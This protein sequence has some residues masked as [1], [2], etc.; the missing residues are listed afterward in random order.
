M[1]EHTYHVRF[2][3]K[4]ESNFDMS[5]DVDLPWVSSTYPGSPR[6][7]TARTDMTHC[8]SVEADHDARVDQVYRSPVRGLPLV[9]K[10]RRRMVSSRRRSTIR[11]VHE[12]NSLT[13]PP[14]VVSALACREQPVASSTGFLPAPNSG[15]SG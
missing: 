9:Q 14:R 1:E 5:H 8:C 7:S 2:V 6:R 15:R 4:A 12:S 10:V 3:G 11:V 13:P